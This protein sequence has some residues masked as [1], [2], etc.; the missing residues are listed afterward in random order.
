MIRAYGALVLFLL[1]ATAA[2]SLYHPEESNTLPVK[3]D[4]AVEPM[5]FDEF[6]QRMLTLA[7]SADS[8]PVDGKPNRDRA[9]LLA[10]VQAF[11]QKRN[12]STT[13]LAVH[14]VDLLRLGNTDPR[15]GDPGLY[16]DQ[17]VNLLAPHTR[18]RNLNYF[19]LTT[20]SAVHAARGD[21]GE[22]RQAILVHESATIDAEMPADVK[23]WSPA[24]RTWIKKMDDEYVPHYLTIRLAEKTSPPSVETEEPTPLFPLP[25]KHKPAEPV[26]FLNEAGQYEPGSLSAAERAKLPPDALPV[27]QQLLLWYPGDTR[28]YW[29]LAELYAAEGKLVEANEI[30]FQLG[31]SKKYGNRKLM[32]EHRRAVVD[33]LEARRKADEEAAMKAYPVSLRTIWIY[34]GG[35][36]LIAVVAFVRGRRRRGLA[37]LTPDCCGS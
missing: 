13:E 4:G 20:L 36:V 7:N 34:F 31:W 37:G 2:G 12:P 21:A 22:L 26:R 35:V 23:G 8:Q 27:V 5:P 15:P 16:L 17:A 1:A 28:L 10:R 19:L 25:M 6:R 29:L 24:Q 18:D 9:V 33:A 30:F 3:S 14:G 32:M 11:R